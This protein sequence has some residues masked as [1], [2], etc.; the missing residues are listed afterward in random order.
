MI[1]QKV[2]YY[3]DIKNHNGL[4]RQKE[5]FE[6]FDQLQDFLI[7]TT[8]VNMAYRTIKEFNDAYHS[9]VIASFD[10]ETGQQIDL[11]KMIHSP[12]FNRLHQRLIACNDRKHQINKRHYIKPNSA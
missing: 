4:T 1:K 6:T 5:C 9:I 7:D 2:Y 3:M 8:K 10:Q 12:K 11:F